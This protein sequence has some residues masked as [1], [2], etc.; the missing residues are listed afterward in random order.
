MKGGRYMKGTLKS[1]AVILAVAFIVLI[2]SVSFTAKRRVTVVCDGKTKTITTSAKT[3]GTLLEENGI[4]IGEKDIIRPNIDT[5]VKDGMIILIKRAVPVTIKV[6]GKVLKVKSAEGTVEK[7]LK[8]EGIN[9]NEKDKV[10]PSLDSIVKPNMEI[11]ITR[12]VEKVEVLSKPIPFKVIKK[13]NND[14]LKGSIKVIQEGMEG[15]LEVKTKVVLEDGKVI[16]TK[17]ISEVIKK[18]P[19][20]KIVYVGTLGFFTPS[21]GGEPIA[22][23]RKLTMK[24]TKYTSSYECTGKRPGDRGFGRTATGTIAR[25]NKN[26]FST[27]AVD[28]DVIPLGTRLYIED[29]GFAIAEDT[30]GAVKG[31]MID[32][33]F[34]PGTEEFRNWRTKYVDVYILR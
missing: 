25:R 10:F 12:V 7:L 18:R 34:E 6:D 17:K 3:V 28:P 26:G 27:V 2:L 13:P 23:V 16:S 1:R 14:M 24:A 21:R 22:Y 4:Y 15:I 8:S 9:L 19:V 29:Y 5:K 33:Y 20:D 32:L 31:Y 11:K 30:G